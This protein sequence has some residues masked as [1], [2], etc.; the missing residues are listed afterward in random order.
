[1][2]LVPSIDTRQIRLLAVVGALYVTQGIPLGLAMETL[3]SLLRRD[4]ASLAGLAFLPLVG[5]PW[6]IKFLW[7]PLVD[8]HWSPRLG[9]RRSWIL[10]MQSLVLLCLIVVSTIGISPSTVG[11]AI[12][13]FALASLASATQDTATDGMAAEQFEGAML[14]RANAVQVAGTMIGFFLGG[15][16]CLVIIGL[17][18][19]TAGF[20]SMSIVVLIGL[21]LAMLWREPAT[22]LAQHRQEKARLGRFIG[23]RGA[24][25]ILAVALLTAMTASASFGLSKLFLVDRGWTLDAIGRIGLAGGAATIFLGCGGGAWL[26]TRIGLRAVLSVS[27]GAG[28]CG[29]AIWT[30][31]AGGL[32]AITQLWVLAAIVLGSIGSGGASVSAMTL[33][34]RFAGSGNQAGTDMTAVQSTRD[35]G[36]ITTSMIATMMAASIGYGGTFA[37]AAGLGLATVG[38]ISTRRAVQSLFAGPPNIYEAEKI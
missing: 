15:S 9:K 37:A 32:V 2:S 12:A 10:P 14:V 17:F 20:L 5:L 23:R 24:P 3:P 7:A 4:G 25:I 8:N 19:R 21:A 11:V 22:A 38:L 31:Q 33:A 34:M 16:G 26:I 6:I 29:A 35:F 18:G 36:E 13:L 28:C 27:L 1:M 30:A